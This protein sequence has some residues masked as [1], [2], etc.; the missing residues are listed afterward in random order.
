MA[1]L[2]FNGRVNIAVGIVTKAY[3]EARLLQASGDAGGSPTRR[4]NDLE[5]L[6]V[7][8]SKDDTST[9]IIRETAH[10]VFGEPKV[11]PEPWGGDRIIDWPI[12]MDLPKAQRCKDE[13]GYQWPYDAVRL[14]NPLGPNVSHPFF[15]F[16]REGRSFVFVDT[17]TGEVST[18]RE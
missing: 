2:S 1:V 14:R 10:G 13:A 18:E 16:E 9:V 12:D 7:V 4:P 5:N 8:F 11:F 3:P 6:R 15:I 17:V